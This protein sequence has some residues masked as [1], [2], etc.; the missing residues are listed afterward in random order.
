M[1][2]VGEAPPERREGGGLAQEDL[3]VGEEEQDEGDSELDMDMDCDAGIEEW[4]RVPF[5]VCRCTVL[6]LQSRPV[7]S[8]D[9]PE[10]GHVDRQRQCK[11]GGLFPRPIVQESVV[12]MRESVKYGD[13]FQVLNLKK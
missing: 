5:L 3:D 4:T 10:R 11:E 1:N 12:P 6:R 13:E 9:P 8:P 2:A 7:V